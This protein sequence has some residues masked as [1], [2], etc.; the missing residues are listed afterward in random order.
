MAIKLPAGVRQRKNGSY[1]IRVS[2]GYDIRG[3]QI[4]KSKVYQP[5]DGMTDRQIEKELM[6]QVILLDE[7][8]KGQLAVKDVKFEAL[9][10]EWL[11][12]TA[13][14]KLSENTIK[15][16][17]QMRDRVYPKIG[18]LYVSQITTRQIQRLIDDLAVNGKNLRSGEPLSRE[19]VALHFCLI[20]GVFNYAMK[21]D[22]I[23]SNPCNRV[24]LPPK[25][26]R[27]KNIYTLTEIEE[28]F[29]ALETEKSILRVFVCLAVYSGMRSGELLGLEWRDINFDHNIINVRRQSVFNKGQGSK[30]KRTKTRKSVRSLKL[31][32][33]AME[34][35]KA[36]KAEQDEQREMLAG[37]W[38]DNDK[39][40]TSWEDGRP[41][42]T[43]LPY[44][45]FKAFCEKKGFRFCDIHSMRHLHASALI[46]AG[47][48]IV[49]VS[50][51]LGHGSPITTGNVYLHEL[52][53]AQARTADVIA[54][55]FDFGRLKAAE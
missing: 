7:S 54:N 51:D 46:F 35:L 24:S 17:R 20:S 44:K 23:K 40:F 52:Q 13:L 22:I 29:Q 36:Y 10:E 50:H 27:E 41:L 8:C 12:G 4:R 53:E 3:K 19:T 43:T 25:E 14:L 39:V 2:C 38:A 1:E 15:R 28:I 33:Y 6:R 47:V 30:D 45:W 32:D 55:A 31:P 48:D 42:C 11:A 34:M 5:E 26:D 16:Y 37:Y 18:H 21:L 49:T 9:A